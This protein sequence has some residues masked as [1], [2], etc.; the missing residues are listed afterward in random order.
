VYGILRWCEATGRSAPANVGRRLDKLASQ[1]QPVDS[2]LRWRRLS[3]AE[4]RPDD[5]VPGWC[6]GSA[7]FA[8]LWLLAERVLHDAGFRPLAEGAALDALGPVESGI[9]LCCG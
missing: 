2:G 9:D 1:A 8:L 3:P 7:G 5:F 4:N 6:N